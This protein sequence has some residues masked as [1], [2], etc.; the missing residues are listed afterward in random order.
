[1]TNKKENW[2]VII[3]AV[4]VG[5]FFVFSALTKIFPIQSFEFTLQSQLGFS[6]LFAGF[7][8]RY[9]VGLEAGLGL[10]LLL[11]IFGSRKWIIKTAFALTAAFTIHL[12]ILY[13]KVGND[14]NCGCMGDW[15]YMPPLQSIG[16]NIVLMVLLGMIW[17]DARASSN[18]KSNWL[19]T[20]VIAACIATIYFLFPF[21]TKNLLLQKV[22]EDTTVTAPQTDLRK[23]KHFVAFLS[24]TC[25]HCMVAAEELTEMKKANPQFPIYVLMGNI[26]DDS[27]RNG[28]LENFVKESNFSG[29]PY[30]FVDQ[31]LFIELSGGHVPSLY[32]INNTKIE[33]KPSISDINAKEL[34]LWLKQH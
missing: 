6:Q 9:I 16:K 23:G 25:P 2:L 22:Y 17:K 8:A 14:V 7:A 26:K 4:L 34:E 13:F 5:C 29:L 32:W 10:M 31:R 19:A 28:L 3:I 30:S 18:K 27:T 1:M 33:R 20:A 24:L 15:F 21:Q 12:L 11:N